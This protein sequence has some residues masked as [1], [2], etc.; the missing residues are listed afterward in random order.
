MSSQTKVSH[1]LLYNLIIIDS[2]LANDTG[3][4]GI[5]VEENIAYSYI[6][7]HDIYINDV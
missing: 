7:T 3:K 5:T 1:S 2:P 4:Q 6:N